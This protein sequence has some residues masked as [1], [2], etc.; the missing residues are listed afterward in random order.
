MS[1]KNLINFVGEL[2][3][4]YVDHCMGTPH[5]RD[6]IPRKLGQHYGELAANFD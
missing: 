3:M 5:G 1:S 6:Y 2:R 4:D